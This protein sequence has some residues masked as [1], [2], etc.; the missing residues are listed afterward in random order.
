MQSLQG[1]LRQKE[2]ALTR[3]QGDVDANLCMHEELRDVH[4]KL[5]RMAEDLARVE[6]ERDAMKNYIADQVL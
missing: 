1:T 3:V 4:G 6:R 2:E 5:L